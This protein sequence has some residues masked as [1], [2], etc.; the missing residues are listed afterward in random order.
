MVHDL[1]S[2]LADQL[3]DASGLNEHDLQVQTASE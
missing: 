3:A 2:F 1:A